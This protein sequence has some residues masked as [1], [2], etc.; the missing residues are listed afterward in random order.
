MI[1]HP[2]SF[3]KSV[4]TLSVALTWWM[5]CL[6][7]STGIGQTVTQP[8]PPRIAQPDQ[9][10]VSPVSPATGSSSTALL[11]GGATQSSHPA[12]GVFESVHRGL[13]TGD[14]AAFAL[15]LAPQVYIS[16]RTGEHGYFSANQATALLEYFLRTRKVTGLVFSTIGENATI[17]YATGSATLLYRG[18]RQIVQV[19]VAASRT[20]G[21]WFI[22]QLN[23]Y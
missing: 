6:T 7:P 21:Q 11:Q 14:V 20:G 4:A 17:P 23:I 3:L 10:R 18:N 22:T 2:S 1:E 5:L 15:F 8:Q 19:Y 16:L 12:A 9:P 13:T